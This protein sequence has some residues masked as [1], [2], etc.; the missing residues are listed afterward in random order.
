MP[1]RP[2]REDHVKADIQAK[3]NRGRVRLLRNN[4]G[5]LRTPYG[6]FISFGLG[7]SGGKLLPGTSDLI[8]WHTV[9]ITH[10]MVGL[11]LAVFAAVEVKDLD[12]PTEAQLNFIEQVRAAGGLAGVAHSAEEAEAILSAGNLT[13]LS[14]LAP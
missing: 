12:T 2:S 5:K 1:S 9:E 6:G 11:R 8:G 13:Q 3:L 14:T 10:E 7:S 4:V